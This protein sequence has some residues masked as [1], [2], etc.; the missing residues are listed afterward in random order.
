MIRLLGRRLTP[1]L[2]DGEPVKARLDHGPERVGDILRVEAHRLLGRRFAQRLEDG[3]LLNAGLDHGPER[4]E[5]IVRVEAQ[6]L[7]GRHL[8]LIAPRRRRAVL[9]MAGS[10]SAILCEV[11]HRTS[12]ADARR[13]ASMAASFSMPVSVMTQTVAARLRGLTRR[14]CSRRLALPLEDGELLDAGLGHGPDHVSRN[15][16]V[17]A[18]HLIGGR[19]AQRL[20]DGDPLK[21]GHGHG[22][23]RVGEIV[24]A[25][26]QNLLGRRLAQRF[27]GR[28]LLEVGL[29]RGPERV[30]VLVRVDTV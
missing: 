26:A 15:M 25:E 21:A 6:H 8:P 5:N 24:R 2:E 30:S 28:E 9:V 4:V 10:V 29:S 7:L 12:W 18:Q 16:G 3:E 13:S 23:P 14:I 20:A 11:K 17:E 27:E 1:R 22:P 19:L